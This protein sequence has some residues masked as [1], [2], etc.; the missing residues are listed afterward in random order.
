MEP[1]LARFRD[2]V[3]KLADG[4]GMSGDETD[5]C[6]TTPTGGQRKFLVVHPQWRSKE[7]TNWLRTI[8]KVYVRH[9][10]SQDGRASRGNWVRQRVDS[11]RSDNGCRPVSGLPKNFYDGTWLRTL[12]ERARAE[13]RM[14]P[15]ISLKHSS[16]IQRCG[17]FLFPRTLGLWILFSMVSRYLPGGGGTSSAS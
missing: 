7:V 12:S 2:Y 13:L 10:F 6:G 4:G 11:G 16:T 17:S 5:Y 3:D 1:G 15:E 9:R 14:Q 8:D